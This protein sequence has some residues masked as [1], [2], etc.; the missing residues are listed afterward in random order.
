MAE[1]IV[2]RPILYFGTGTPYLALFTELGM[3]VMNLITGI[4]IGAYINKFSYKTDESKENLCT[5]ELSTGNPAT[6]DKE[7]IQEGCTL[8]I[9]WGYIFP[10]GSSISSPM[11]ALKIRDMDILFDDQGTKIT[12]KCVDKSVKIRQMPIWV[13]KPDGKT[14]LKDFMDAG[15]NSGQGIIIE[16]FS[17]PG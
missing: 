7:T 17:N 2:N 4:P 12:L 15:L 11:V 16:K 1:K 13:P 6:V 3:P 10:D 8:L 9:Q 5:L 14:T